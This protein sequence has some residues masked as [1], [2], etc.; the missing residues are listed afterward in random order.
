[1]PSSFFYQSVLE[2]C[3]QFNPLLLEP[4]VDTEKKSHYTCTKD[5]SLLLLQKTSVPSFTQ[6]SRNSSP[7]IIN[8]VDMWEK[9]L[10][11]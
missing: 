1:M 10:T 6:G 4:N 2:L 9:Q 7:A 5:Y 3:D 8:E 11:S